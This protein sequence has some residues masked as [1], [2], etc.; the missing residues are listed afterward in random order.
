MEV[1][2]D[3]VGGS[4]FTDSLRSLREAGRLI[5]VGF[6][7]GSIPEVKVNRLLLGNTEIIGAGWGGYVMS[8]PQVNREIGAAINA[9]DRAGVRAADRRRALSRWSAPRTR[10]ARSTSAARP[11]SSCS[12]CE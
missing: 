2:F 12:T 7:G 3:P 4:L 6:A 8:R 11:A 1:V 5:V 9:S 10:C